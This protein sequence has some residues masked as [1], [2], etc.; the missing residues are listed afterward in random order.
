MHRGAS[1]GAGILHPRRPLEAQGRI[2]LQN[3][4]RGEILSRK[5]AI[6]MAEENLVD[7][8]GADTRIRQ[9]AL[10]HAPDQRLDILVLMAA[11][12][13]MAPADDASRHGCSPFDLEACPT[14][15]GQWPL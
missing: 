3:Q 14:I 11:E 6:E 12:E 13:R 8:G 2:F 10:R 15:A 5:A 9:R 7:V 4:R 1:R